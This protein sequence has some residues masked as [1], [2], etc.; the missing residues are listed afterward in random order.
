[1]KLLWILPCL[2]ICAC[3]GKNNAEAYYDSAAQQPVVQQA[4][5]AYAAPQS[6][7]NAN[8]YALQ[9]AAYEDN[10]FALNQKENELFQK[11]KNLLSA[12]QELYEREKKLATREADFINRS[13][14]LDYKEQSIQEGRLYAPVSS[15]AAPQQPA[16]MQPAAQPYMAPVY[17]PQPQPQPQP[18]RPYYGTEPQAVNSPSALPV[19]QYN[20]YSAPVAQED[21]IFMEDTTVYNSVS[22][23]VGAFEAAQTGFIIMQHPIQR[24][25][26]RCPASDDVCLQSYERLGYV[27]SANLSRFTAQDEL[28]TAGTYP[29]NTSGQWRENNSIPRW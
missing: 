21:E 6:G 2:A 22:E 27:R 9:P 24:D 3:A 28:N 23:P 25:L 17:Q 4:P 16:M 1:M 13:K 15:G 5:A 26:V 18:Q 19:G 11:E 14:A 29:A 12:Q 8:P 7:T 20:P 10:N